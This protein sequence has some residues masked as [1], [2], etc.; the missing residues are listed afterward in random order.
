[1]SNQVTIKDLIAIREYPHLLGHLAR[2]TKLTELHS[3]WIH[4]CWDTQEDR[5]LQA[6]RLGFKTT[7]VMVIG[8]IWWLLFNPDDR[9]GI[10]RKTFTD[11]ANVVK[12]IR[13]I[14]Q[15]PIIMELFKFAHGYYPKLKT[16]REGILTFNFKKTITPEG[17]INAFGINNTL[18][19][20]HLDKIGFDDFVTADD[21]ISKAKRDNTKFRIR[22]IRTNIIE[23]EPGKTC[24]F[25]GTP[26][27]KNDAWTICP[28]PLKFSIYKTGILSE[29]EIEDKRKK[30][31]KSLFSCNYELIHMP[32]EGKLFANPNYSK[33]VYSVVGT[34]G[35]IDAAFD[36]IATN[37]LTFYAKKGNN[38]IQGFGKV[39]PGHVKDWIDVIEAEYKKRRCKKIYVEKNADKG[40]T[41][42]L[43]KDRNLV[44]SD[45]DEG[46]NKHE[47]ISAFLYDQ[48]E[49][50]EWDE[51]TDPE[52]LLQIVE[53][54]KGEKPD[55]APDSA[56]SLIQRG[57]LSS[58]KSGGNESL[59]K[60]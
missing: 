31:T 37:A 22:E 52:Y 60:W 19:G 24:F 26:W 50:I 12:T 14:M 15:I 44:V 39:Y 25:L 30:T 45:Y 51:K 11:A 6:H 47:K 1:M 35:H 8:P 38:K 40:Y 13:E 16:K 54:E 56:A 4:Y 5:S 49:N 27:H 33:W 3:K 2:K 7:A 10:I 32:E 23:T 28:E 41:A 58:I 55:D 46:M 48:W 34:I 42:K 29:Q 59:W 20:V 18:T 53:Y 43:L 36:G 17:S 9:V 21:R 57:G